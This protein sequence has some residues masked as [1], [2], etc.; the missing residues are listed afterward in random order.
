MDTVA[1]TAHSRFEFAHT[2]TVGWEPAWIKGCSPIWHLPTVP[3]LSKHP[4]PSLQTV[5]KVLPGVFAHAGNSCHVK[6][7]FTY[8]A[9]GSSG[10][11]VVTPLSRYF[12]RYSWYG[13]KRARE[14]GSVWVC[15]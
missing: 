13:S 1:H 5:C 10:R 9:L 11:Q 12:Q 6:S 3:T 2:C 14:S 8:G 15:D 7:V 4:D